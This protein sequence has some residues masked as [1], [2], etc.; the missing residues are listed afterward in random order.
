MLPDSFP[1]NVSVRDLTSRLQAIRRRRDASQ[2]SPYL[3]GRFTRQT[4]S[5]RKVPLQ[6]AC[7]QY[8]AKRDFLSKIA[9]CSFMNRSCSYRH[10]LRFVGKLEVPEVPD[11]RSLGAH[12]G[13][14]KRNFI[15]SSVKGF[16]RTESNQRRE[17]FLNSA[18]VPGI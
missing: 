16:L 9:T 8:F 15:A 6:L 10:I 12:L 1:P 13:D 14:H 4:E 18:I 2:L 3:R 5:V 11:L 7:F 17:P